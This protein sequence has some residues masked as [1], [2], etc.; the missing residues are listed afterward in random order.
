MIGKDIEHTQ[1]NKK[2]T[3]NII[4]A[5]RKG[6]LSKAR[7]V[8]ADAYSFAVFQRAKKCLSLNSNLGVQ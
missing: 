3:E 4:I 2:I 8:T 1:L 6:G 5:P 7:R